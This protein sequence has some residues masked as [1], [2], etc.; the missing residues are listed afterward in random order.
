MADG[1]KRC[2]WIHEGLTIVPNGDVHACCHKKPD[3]LG[4]INENTLEEIFNGDRVKEF[5]QQEIDGTLSCVAKCIIPQGEVRNDSVHRDFRTELRRLQVEFGERC[6]IRCIMCPQ[7]HKSTLELDPEILV[8]NVD[9][10]PSCT[11]IHF[12]GGEPTILKSARR[13]FD[14][15][16]EQE[17]AVC[18]RS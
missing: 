3:V 1:R 13:L 7:D 15:C 5:R 9:I 18:H 12:F 8:R 16:I 10:P 4:N 11:N 2:S 17:A 14:H 6:N